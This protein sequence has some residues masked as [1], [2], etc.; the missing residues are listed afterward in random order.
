[1]LGKRREY[2]TAGLDTGD[3]HPDPVTQLRRWYDD[4][5]D[6]GLEEPE[7]MLLST[8]GPTG[9]PTSRYVLMRGLDERGVTFFT[10][11]LSAKARDLEVNPAVALTFGWLALHRQVRITG[12]AARLPA[13]ESDAYFAARTRASRIGAWASPQS[14]VLSSREDL[15]IR[16]AEIE[17]RFG[18]DDIPRPEHWG[19]YLVDP[20]ALEFWQGRTSRLHDR[21]RYRREG[22]GWAIERLA[23]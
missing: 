8:V 9:A 18:G 6:A 15:D 19:G 14:E 17:A 7:A 11:Y 22:G 1:V 23:P 12:T 16:I 3:L 5:R 10:N 13:G 20:D 2:E 4:A 21:L